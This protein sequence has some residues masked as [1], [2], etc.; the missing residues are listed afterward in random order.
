[1]MRD[2]GFVEDGVQIIDYD[3]MMATSDI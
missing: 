1:M 2:R 3:K